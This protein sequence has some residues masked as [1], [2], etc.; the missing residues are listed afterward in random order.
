M[1]TPDA[2]IEFRYGTETKQNCGPYPKP[3]PKS[4]DQ[5]EKP[6]GR[7]V[8]ISSSPLDQKVTLKKSTTHAYT[9]STGQDWGAKVTT[10]VSAGFTTGP[11]GGVNSNV[12]VSGEV[13]D[14]FSKSY[15]DTFSQT[16]EETFEYTLPGGVVWQFQFFI[17]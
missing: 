17:K 8:H 3:T 6:D 11:A 10:A 7:W 4:C 16:N 14:S 12:T 2:K 15:S 5:I 13:S 1:G 9:H